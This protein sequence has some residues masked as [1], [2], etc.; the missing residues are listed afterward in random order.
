[1][2]PIAILAALF[3][4]LAT[5]VSAQVIKPHKVQVEKKSTSTITVGKVSVHKT[6]RTT[7]FDS[8][9]VA[10]ISRVEVKKNK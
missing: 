7:V 3:L 9:K 4:M 8:P 2:K 6:R 1:M 10:V 5:S